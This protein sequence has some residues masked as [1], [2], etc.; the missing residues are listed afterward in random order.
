MISEHPYF[1]PDSTFLTVREN[2]KLEQEMAHLSA[3]HSSE[4]VSCNKN[5][6]LFSFQN[7]KYLKVFDSLYQ[8]N[9][10]KLKT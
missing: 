7:C 9:I 5:P 4:F 6:V 8:P 2:W 3:S 1:R 10:G